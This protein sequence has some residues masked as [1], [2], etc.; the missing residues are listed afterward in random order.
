LQL[1]WL[2][3]LQLYTQEEWALVSYVLGDSDVKWKMFVDLLHGYSEF[4]NI[5][6]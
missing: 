5:F 2:S 3:F 6:I 4:N 1:F